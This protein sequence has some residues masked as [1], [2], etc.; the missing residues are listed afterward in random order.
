MNKN[1]CKNLSLTFFTNFLIYVKFCLVL[2]ALPV[3]VNTRRRYTVVQDGPK[4]FSSK[5]LFISSQNIDGF[6]RFIFQNIV[7]N[8]MCNNTYH[9]RKCSP[10]KHFSPELR[11]YLLQMFLYSIFSD[12]MH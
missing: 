11:C 7:T 6:Y 4:K 10:V 8:T 1:V 12:K 3:F 2:D 9:F 5:L